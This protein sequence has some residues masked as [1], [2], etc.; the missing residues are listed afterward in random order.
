VRGKRMEI[1]SEMGLQRKRE[2]E[3]RAITF[4]FPCNIPHE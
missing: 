2:M 1:E 4:F 3:Q